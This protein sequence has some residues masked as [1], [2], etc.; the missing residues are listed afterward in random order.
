MNNV[1]L[2]C[3]SGG[4]IG[5]IQR[6]GI[7]EPFIG[8]VELAGGIGADHTIPAYRST[9]PR[10]TGVNEL[11][12]NAARRRPSVSGSSRQR[13]AID[14]REDHTGNHQQERA[15]GGDMTMRLVEPRIMVLFH[16]F[17]LGVSY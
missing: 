4:D 3:S 14:E 16:C 10:A 1:E 11:G 17:L 8:K 15:V 13:S 5:I 7:V 9:D 6:T 12:T 2:V